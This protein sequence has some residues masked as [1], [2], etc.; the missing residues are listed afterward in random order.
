MLHIFYYLSNLCILHHMKNTQ[1]IILAAGKGTRMGHDG[2]KVLADLKRKPLIKHLL[3]SVE[4]VAE[5]SPIIV[6]GHQREKVEQ[7]LGDKYKYVSQKEQKGTG[8]AVR[9][10]LPFVQKENIFVLYGDMPLLKAESISKMVTEHEQSK[11][12][13]SMATTEVPD[14]DDWR[15]GFYR[16]GRII[17]EN[18]KIVG[19]KEQKDAEEKELEIK[20]VNPA[21]FLMNTQWARENI[22]KIG[23]QN[24]Q[25]E[26]YLTDL[27]AIRSKEGAEIN[28]FPIDP[29][30]AL[31]ANTQ[32][33][34]LILGRFV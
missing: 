30:E 14:F 6:V 28:S 18:G 10:A 9:E 24:A 25:G 11:A 31:G 5:H 27:V 34:L 8:H 21:Y 20:E 23:N 7:A 32:E 4:K 3:E 13:F 15:S 1:I 33:E 19:I 12:V 29:H 22:K 17:R 16:F 26:I 2:P